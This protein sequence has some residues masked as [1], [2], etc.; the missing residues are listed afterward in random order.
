MNNIPNIEVGILASE[1]IVFSLSEGYTTTKQTISICGECIARLENNTIIIEQEGSTLLSAKEVTL[2]PQTLTE[3]H[4]DISNVVIGVNF[5]WEQK[6]NQR[7]Q[8]TL[9]LIIAGNTIQAINI[10]PIENYLISVISSEMSANSS[11]NLLKAHSIISRSWLLAQI[12]KQ[13]E[14]VNQSAK[15]KTIHES[16]EEYIRWYDRED[17]TTFHVCADDH[18]QRYQG[19]TKAH[20]PNVA[21][22]IQETQGEVLIYNNTICDARFSKACGGMTEI[23]ENCW[24]PVNHPYLQGFADNHTNPEG[25][26]LD[27][28]QE[29]NAR[30]FIHG[31]PDAFCNTTDRKILNQVLNDY[32]HTASDFYR[33]EVTYK[34]E[35]FSALIKERSGF[36]FGKIK[37]L[38]PVERGTSGRLLKLKIEGEKLIKTV[39]KE[40]E[41]RR[42]LSKSH[43]YSAAFTIETENGNNKY[44]K[45][46]TLRGAGWGHGVGLCQIGAAVMGEKGYSYQEILMHY[47]RGADIEKKY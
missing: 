32:D 3:N 26:Q 5:H 33:W 36:D 38:I 6:E 15:Y 28:T 22:A 34:Q 17:H 41:I 20:N 39:G 16:D 31:K 11:L 4:F 47:F 9:K 46:F 35:E 14:L 45:S 21:K 10:L 43:L 13:E 18:C 23:F 37:A 30:A 42:W 1:S 27:L 2:N 12:E 8:G 25:F 7:F 44:P 24:E 19:I 40:L 29:E